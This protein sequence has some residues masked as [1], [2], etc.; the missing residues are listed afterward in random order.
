MTFYDGDEDDALMAKISRITYNLSDM[1]I[2][3]SILLITFKNLK[4]EAKSRAED[5]KDDPRLYYKTKKD[6][7]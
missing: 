3:L 7:K 4:D 2:I 1:L 5:Q 6:D